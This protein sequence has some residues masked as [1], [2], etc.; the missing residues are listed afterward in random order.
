LT[1]KENS[2][3]YKIEGSENFG[4][5]IKSDGTK[6]KDITELISVAL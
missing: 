6:I 3:K 2:E 1:Q 5:L 4:Y